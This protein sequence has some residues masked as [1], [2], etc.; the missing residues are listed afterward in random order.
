MQA[1]P[2]KIEA[3]P[4]LIVNPLGEVFLDGEY[5]G[6]STNAIEL[7]RELGKPV[8]QLKPEDFTES[9]VRDLY[10]AG[11]SLT[12]VNLTRRVWEALPLVEK[13][14]ECQVGYWGGSLRVTV[15]V[16]EFTDSLPCQAFWAEVDRFCQTHGYAQTVV[17]E[18]KELDRFK[19]A[20]ARRWKNGPDHNRPYRQTEIA[21]LL[22]DNAALPD[23][24]AAAK[25]LTADAAA[26]PDAARINFL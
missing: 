11:A 19:P 23:I 7:A 16:R 20:G 12:D 18:G 10:A 21:A 4:H 22:P 14:S 2:I 13:G 9:M 17:D 26:L 6:G 8:R 24:L 25:T 15:E 3:E 1:E 5:V